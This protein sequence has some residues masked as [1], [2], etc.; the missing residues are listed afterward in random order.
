MVKEKG[1]SV[2]PVVAK[3]HI[4][5]SRAAES[6]QGSDN[7]DIFPLFDPMRRHRPGSAQSLEIL[8][9]DLPN[10]AGSVLAKRSRARA[11]R[12]LSG[13]GEGNR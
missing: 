9:L 5:L 4:S 13:R 7:A 10:L 12:P 11:S 3:H 8:A 2:A 1:K 6:A